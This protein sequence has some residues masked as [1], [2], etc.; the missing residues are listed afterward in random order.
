MLMMGPFSR[1]FEAIRD[2]AYQYIVESRAQATI[3]IS[4]AWIQGAFAILAFCLIAK[5]IMDAEGDSFAKAAKNY[6][7]ANAK[8]FFVGVAVICA[9]PITGALSSVARN[10]A[11]QALTVVDTLGGL[12]GEAD[13]QM[14]FAADQFTNFPII[15]AKNMGIKTIWI[16]QADIRAMQANM[17][18]SG[19][20]LTMGAKAIADR[21][22]QVSQDIQKAEAKKANASTQEKKMLDQRLTALK[23]SQAELQQKQTKLAMA[24]N[25][26]CMATLQSVKE[27]QEFWAN[28]FKTEDGILAMLSRISGVLSGEYTMGQLQ[29]G[30]DAGANKIAG[31]VNAENRLAQL[32]TATDSLATAGKVM[33]AVSNVGLVG[34]VIRVIDLIFASPAYLVGYLCALIFMIGAVIFGITIIKESF[35]I[36]TYIAGFLI[37]T[38]VATAIAAPVAPAFFVAFLHEKTENYGRTFLG[39][40]MSMIFAAS[41]LAGMAMVA[42]GLVNGIRHSVM[43]EAYITFTDVYTA[44]S[45]GEMIMFSFYG[46]AGMVASGMCLSFVLDL[47]KRGAQIGAAIWSGNSP[48]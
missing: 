19:Q 40:W 7:T 39:F 32:K 5:G 23:T 42:N 22:G 1:A 47:I 2:V 36:L 41:G 34:N 38:S 10:Q 25:E 4:E 21:L 6:V 26:A 27:A 11:L 20:A 48:Y 14:K 9:N 31:L 16:S 37:S 35:G 33:G 3:S 30:A 18:G 12:A 43:T 17:I 29:K 8:I 45:G 28:P 15:A 46:L 13:N 24:S 44:G